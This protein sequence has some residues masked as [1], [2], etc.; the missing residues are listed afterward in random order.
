MNDYI[1]VSR[2][3]LFVWTLSLAVLTGVLMMLAIRLDLETLLSGSPPALKVGG[4]RLELSEFAELK[5]QAGP[6]AA[7][8]SDRTFAAELVETFLWAEEGRRRKLDT[9]T[10]YREKLLLFDMAIASGSSA[11]SWSA[12]LARSMFLSEELARLT[13]EAVTNMSDEKAAEESVLPEELLPA[14]MP[15][16]LHVQTILAPDEAIASKI[17]AAAASGTSFSTLNASYSLSPYAPVGGDMGLVGIDDLP[18][19]V[20]AA[21]ATSTSGSIIRL[22]ADEQGVHLFRLA[23]SMTNAS[24]SIRVNAVRA[25][26]AIRRAEKNHDALAAELLRIRALIPVYLHPSL[27]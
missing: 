10:E 5:K 17:I 7:N 16:K 27:R 22:F 1:R 8:L 9:V 2:F 13:R 4:T 21:I 6:A 20:F 26:A 12:D 23:E 3:S 24:T 19:G 14:T 15:T 11:G 25:K 18:P